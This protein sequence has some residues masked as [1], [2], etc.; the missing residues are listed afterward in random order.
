MA[1]PGIRQGSLS[2]AKL[3][4]PVLMMGIQHCPPGQCDPIIVEGLITPRLDSP[5]AYRIVTLC[6]SSRLWSRVK[7]ATQ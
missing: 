3:M 6:D 2:G 1:I 5:H 7:R 4:K